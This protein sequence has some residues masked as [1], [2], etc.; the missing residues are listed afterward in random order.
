MEYQNNIRNEFKG[1]RLTQD[2]GVECQKHFERCFRKSNFF[3][4]FAIF[5]EFLKIGGHLKITIFG[6]FFNFDPREN[7]FD[8]LY[9]QKTH[10]IIFSKSRAIY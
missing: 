1:T 5:L 8:A 6:H 4:I 7:I 3:V 9:E 10:L 2:E